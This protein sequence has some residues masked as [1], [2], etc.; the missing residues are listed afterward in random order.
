MRSWRTTS[1]RLTMPCRNRSCSLAPGLFRV[2]RYGF[3]GPCFPGLFLFSQHHKLVSPNL[4]DEMFPPLLIQK[5][6]GYE[7]SFYVQPFA[8]LKIF[9]SDIRMLFPEEQ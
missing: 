4:G 3:S 8:V 1:V 7:L 5:I 6:P 2:G 9:L